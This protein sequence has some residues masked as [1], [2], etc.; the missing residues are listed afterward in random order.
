MS[1]L[2]NAI[3]RMFPLSGNGIVKRLRLVPDKDDDGGGVANA[4]K[5]RPRA[6]P[7]ADQADQAVA[8]PHNC[9]VFRSPAF[10]LGTFLL[11]V[12]MKM[13]DITIMNRND[14]A[15]L[16]FRT[17]VGQTTTTLS[18]LE[19]DFK[20]MV[21]MCNALACWLVRQNDTDAY[22]KV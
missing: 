4:I 15:Q 16:L 19:K 3:G 22:D 8:R 11:N 2:V 6:A 13:Q 14:P 21:D 5:R 1:T 18:R 20:Y 12:S 17:T 9:M 10:S 7:T